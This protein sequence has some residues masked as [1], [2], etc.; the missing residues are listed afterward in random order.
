MKVFCVSQ[1]DLGINIH[2]DGHDEDEVLNE[3]KIRYQVANKL[4]NDVVS[5]YDG[6]KIKLDDLSE[7]E[8]GLINRHSVISAVDLVYK[9][10][11][12]NSLSQNAVGHSDTG[13]VSWDVRIVRSCLQ[14]IHDWRVPPEF[15]PGFLILLVKYHFYT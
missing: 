2:S 7:R 3:Q 13:F 10:L 8:Y 4:F 14:H 5:E 15:V 6:K 1:Q 9:M 11:H 12:G